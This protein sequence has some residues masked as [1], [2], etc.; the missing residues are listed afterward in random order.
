MNYKRY[1]IPNSMVFLTIV[2]Y[3]R[4]P[5]LLE[6]INLIQDMYSP[7]EKI[8]FEKKQITTMTDKRNTTE[9]K[10]IREKNYPEVLKDYGGNILL[11]GITYNKKTRKHLSYISRIQITDYDNNQ[12]YIDVNP[13]CVQT[14]SAKTNLDYNQLYKKFVPCIIRQHIFDAFP[15]VDA[16]SCN[17]HGDIRT[18]VY[19]DFIEEIKDV[20]KS[21]HY[22]IESEEPYKE[23]NNRKTT[24]LKYKLNI[25]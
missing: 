2:T 7:M 21:Y 3:N 10:Q 18:I 5:I 14:L 1:F 12:F 24:I 23:K 19:D 16:F 22:A 15:C 9:I 17:R 20:L 8:D 13:D 25:C 6:Q 11:V 4:N